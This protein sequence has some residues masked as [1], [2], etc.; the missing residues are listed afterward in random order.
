MP[1]RVAFGSVELMGAARGR[2]LNNEPLAADRMSYAGKHVAWHAL[3]EQPKLRSRD[4]T[5]G[6][7]VVV[8]C[9][10]PRRSRGWV[11]RGYGKRGVAGHLRGWGDVRRGCQLDLYKVWISHLR[12]YPVLKSVGPHLDF[13]RVYMR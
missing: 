4:G 6:R 11:G 2:T 1:I 8:A 10:V 13:R 7:V 12:Y 5:A 9:D 3:A